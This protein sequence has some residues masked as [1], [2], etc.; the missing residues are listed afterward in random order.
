MKTGLFLRNA[1]LAALMMLQAVVPCFV[2]GQA[3][4]VP[5]SQQA[6][7]PGAVGLL[8]TMSGAVYM[9]V[10]NGPEVL[11]K[12]GDLFAAGAIIRT[13][14]EAGTSL[15]PTPGDGGWAHHRRRRAF[16]SRLHG[17]QPAHRRDL[18]AAAHRDRAGEVLPAEQ[19][20]RRQCAAR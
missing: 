14:S 20:L 18:R 1:G 12:P 16:V 4:Q 6:Q 17:A 7:V 15:G 5:A 2:W 19:H 9:R 10:G 8:S 3:A 11:M 13:D